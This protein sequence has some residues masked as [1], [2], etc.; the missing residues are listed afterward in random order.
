[1]LPVALTRA[2]G[3]PP[4]I[5]PIPIVDSGRTPVVGLIYP[6]REPLTPLVTALLAEAHRHGGPAA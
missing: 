1:V 6:L 2:V 3:L 5:R 4:T